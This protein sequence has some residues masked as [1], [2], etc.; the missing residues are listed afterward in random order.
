MTG[1]SFK[2]LTCAGAYSWNFADNVRTDIPTSQLSLQSNYFRKLDITASGS[3]SDANMGANL[4]FPQ[5]EALAL[6]VTFSGNAVAERISGNFDLGLTYHISRAWKCLRSVP[7]V[8]LA[9]SE[10]AANDDG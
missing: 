8:K 4:N 7:L 10:L 5:R 3:Y 6:P 2:P 9:R 1:G